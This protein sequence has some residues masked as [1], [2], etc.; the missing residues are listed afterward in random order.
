MAGFLRMALETKKPIVPTLIIGAE[1]TNLNIGN[2]DFSKIV[3]G[4]RIPMPLNMLPLPAKWKIVFLPPIDPTTEDFLKIKTKKQ[5]ELKAEKIRKYHQRFLNKQLTKRTYIY[6]KLTGKMK[7]SV[8][9][10]LK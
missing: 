8:A 9:E 5:F 4:L 6:S 3:K 7:D 2:F 1:E 10:L